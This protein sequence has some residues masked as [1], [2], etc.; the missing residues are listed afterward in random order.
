MLIDVI[1]QNI[2]GTFVHGVGSE[3]RKTPDIQA[4]KISRLQREIF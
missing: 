2:M 3:L 4:V 1:A